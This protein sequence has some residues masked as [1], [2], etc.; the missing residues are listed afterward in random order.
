MC[1]LQM[2]CNC[3]DHR[4]ILLIMFESSDLQR[5]NQVCRQFRTNYVVLL[6]FNGKKVET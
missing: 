1:H 4:R 5:I 3:Y 2:K 6:V